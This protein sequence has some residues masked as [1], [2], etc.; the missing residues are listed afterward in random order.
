MKKTVG[1]I[2]PNALSSL[3]LIVGPL[4]LLWGQVPAST[5]WFALL[6]VAAATDLMDGRLA[7]RWGSSTAVGAVLDTTADKVFTLSLMLKL[8]LVDV[9]PM[10]LFGLLLAQ[11][12]LLLIAGSAYAKKFGKVPVPE[13]TAHAAA[14]IAGITV[15]FGVLSSSVIPVLILSVLL[16]LANALH[17]TVAIR[18]VLGLQP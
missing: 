14:L 6:V 12:L 8:A 16:V 1:I 5:E 9:L 11:Y 3:R 10:A 4:F 17:L 15:L 13:T 2:V 18:R 7:R